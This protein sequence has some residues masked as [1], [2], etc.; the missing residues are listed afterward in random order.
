MVLTLM[1]PPCAG[2]GFLGGALGRGGGPFGGGGGTPTTLRE[3][4]V[5]G[6]GGLARS[7]PMSLQ[8]KFNDFRAPARL[9][10]TEEMRRRWAPERAP[11]AADAG[12]VP[13]VGLGATGLGG[14]GG[15]C[16]DLE[17]E[18]KAADEHA[19]GV[20]GPFGAAGLALLMD[21]S[22]R[23]SLM[24]AIK[25]S[26]G[27]ADISCGRAA[28]VFGTLRCDSVRKDGASPSRARAQQTARGRKRPRQCAARK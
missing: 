26:C 4:R 16:L 19:G 11:R 17:L 24:A 27:L 15:G 3:L 12:G 25:W 18:E 21:D 5:G 1:G 7:S 20:A 2:R 6:G 10:P 9:W 8:L 23:L 13:P 22:R 14:D 28:E